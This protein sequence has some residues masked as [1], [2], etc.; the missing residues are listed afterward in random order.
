MKERRGGYSFRR[1]AGDQFSG[2]LHTEKFIEI[3]KVTFDEFI[4]Y[5]FFEFEFFY[6]L[7]VIRHHSESDVELRF[8]D[9]FE[10]IS[11][12]QQLIAVRQI[13]HG[14]DV[15]IHLVDLASHMIV[16]VIKIDIQTAVV[17]GGFGK[18]LYIG[19]ERILEHRVVAVDLIDGDE[20]GTIHNHGGFRAGDRKGG[21][22]AGGDDAA[23]FHLQLDF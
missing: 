11:D 5:R 22:P 12:N 17:I 1:K 19:A 16:C 21:A 20:F 13:I 2:F 10:G 4:N 14:A 3:F 7:H 23:R 18:C 8:K 15:V 6:D 9:S